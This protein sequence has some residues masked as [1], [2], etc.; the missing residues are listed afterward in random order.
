MGQHTRKVHL[1]EEFSRVGKALASP[2]RIEILD[3]L[4][5]GEKTVEALAA[6][7]ELS[8]KNASAHLRVLR[9]ARLVEVRRNGTYM[10]YRLAD[11]SVIA[12]VRQM[13]ALARNRLAEAERAV[14]AYLGGREQLEPIT[15]KE[16]R[17]RVRHGDAVIL[18]VRPTDEYEAGHLPGAVSIPVRELQKR[19]RELPAGRDVVAYCRGPYCVYAVAAVDILR[20]AGFKAR[21]TEVG[22][23]EW[24]LSGHKVAV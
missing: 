19:L 21:R 22:V 17:D 15:A 23:A 6:A 10:Y 18:D 24:K 20:R 1:Y 5:Q 2:A 16:L 11:Q 14:Q 9:A 13:Q 3:I 8:L 7:C 4:A 12:L